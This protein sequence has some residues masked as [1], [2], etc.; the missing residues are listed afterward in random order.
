M[1]IKKERTETDIQIREGGEEFPEE[2]NSEPFY[3]SF[4]SPSV[5]H[6]VHTLLVHPAEHLLSA[7]TSADRAQLN[8]KQATH[9]IFF[10]ATLPL[11]CFSHFLSL[12]VMATAVEAFLSWPS[13]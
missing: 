7:L 10:I 4:I 13:H 8:Y 5:Y 2:L 9:R 6:P 1:R 12:F 3:N 11:K